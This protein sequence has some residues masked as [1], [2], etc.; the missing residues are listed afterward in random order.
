MSEKKSGF[1]LIELLIVISIIGILSSVIFTSLKSSVLD[2]NSLKV[3]RNVDAY[4]KAFQIQLASTG[5]YPTGIGVGKCLGLGYP[6][7]DSDSIGECRNT[8]YALEEGAT[9]NAQLLSHV[10]SLQP[11]IFPKELLIAGTDIY[12]VGAWVQPIFF[13]PSVDPSYSI[14]SVQIPATDSPQDYLTLNYVIEG[15]DSDCYLRPILTTISSNVYETSIEAKNSNGSVLTNGYNN[16][17]NTLCQIL[18]PR[19]NS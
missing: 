9:L 2:A 18:L 4:R 7:I 1:T 5:S 15:P 16:R 6:D 10:P 19:Q 13:P 12:A 17:G 8:T 14:N 11:A 3:A